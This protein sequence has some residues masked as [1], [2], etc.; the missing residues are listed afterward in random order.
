[1]VLDLR[2]SMRGLKRFLDRG[3]IGAPGAALALDGVP[4][5]GVDDEALK[6]Y[7]MDPGATRALEK[8]LFGV[9]LLKP[10]ERGATRA[11]GLMG[12]ELDRVRRAGVMVLEDAVATTV[13]A[14]GVG[15]PGMAV[16]GVLLPPASLSRSFPDGR[17]RA[18]RQTN[19]S[20]K[21]TSSSRAE[22]RTF[23][24]LVCG[25]LK[26]LSSTDRRLHEDDVVSAEVGLISVLPLPTSESGRE[27]RRPTFCYADTQASS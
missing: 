3:R 2:T 27:R 4:R 14:I 26:L 11:S 10:T 21:C 13:A 8:V 19:C 24:D 17:W 1:M 16:R 18:T 22:A 5:V 20:R 12:S 9:E 6:R 7:G 25:G 23:V 15:T